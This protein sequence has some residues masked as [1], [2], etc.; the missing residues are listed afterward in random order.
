MKMLF[1]F[2]IVLILSSYSFSQIPSLSI[3]NEDKSPLEIIKLDV[4]I[5]IIGNIATT[6]YDILFYNPQRRILE[7]EFSMPLGEG[8]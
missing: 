4:K 8:Q 7:G 2:I 1:T 5:N 3:N 6:T